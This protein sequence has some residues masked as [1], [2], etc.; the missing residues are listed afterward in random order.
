MIVVLIGVNHWTNKDMIAKRV[1]DGKLRY[2]MTFSFN[3][4]LIRLNHWN[5]V[6]PQNT[7]NSNIRAISKLHLRQTNSKTWTEVIWSLLLP[8]L[9]APPFVLNI[10]RQLHCVHECISM[11][12][13]HIHLAKRTT[14]IHLPFAGQEKLHLNWRTRGATVM[15]WAKPEVLTTTLD[16]CCV[17]VCVR[18]KP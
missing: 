5:V 2:G 13:T 17:C 8:S 1:R 14:P 18:N 12:N 10:T 15:E 9:S 4:T 3:R 7:L 6:L 16:Y 11:M